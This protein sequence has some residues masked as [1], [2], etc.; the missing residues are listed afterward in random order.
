MSVNPNI[1]PNIYCLLRIACPIPVTSA[2]HERANS[3]ALNTTLLKLYATTMTMERLSGF[4]LMKIHYQR[5]VDYDAVAETFAEQQPRRMLLVV[6]HR[7][8]LKHLA[9]KPSQSTGFSI[10]TFLFINML[11]DWLIL[12]LIFQEIV[13]SIRITRKTRTIFTFLESEEIRQTTYF[14]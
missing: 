8:P 4:G 2:D 12:I 6:V 11:M 14:Y 5:R 7:K 10:I 1:F 13:I 9:D 3:T